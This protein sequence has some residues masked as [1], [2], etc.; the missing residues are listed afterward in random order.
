MANGNRRKDAWMQEKAQAL[1]RLRPPTCASTLCSSMLETSCA[2]KD[3]LAALPRPAKGTRPPP[4]RPLSSLACRCVS[5]KCID[6]G[7]SESDSELSVSSCRKP[8]ATLA[9]GGACGLCSWATA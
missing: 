3:G 6:A 7:L 8:R 9:G 1:K 4:A 2:A 5:K